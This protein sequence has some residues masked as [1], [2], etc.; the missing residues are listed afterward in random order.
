MKKLI[1]LFLLIACCIQANAQRNCTNPHRIFQVPKGKVPVVVKELG[2]APQF[3]I[4]CK[5][6][7]ADIFYKNLKTLGEIK[8]YK[9]EINSLFRSIGYSGVG[10][11]R[12][13]RDKVT[14]TTV[15]FGAVG[16]LGD[17]K[18]NYVYSILVLPEQNIKAWRITALSGCDLYFMN[19]CGNGF[20]YANPPV[21][22]ETVKYVERCTGN[23]KLKVRVVARYEKEECYVC[24]DGSAYEK[25][26]EKNME[27]AEEKIDNIPIGN[28]NSSYPVK[29]IYIDLDKQTFKKLEKMAKKEAQC[30]DDD[31]CCAD[32][33]DESCGDDCE[34]DSGCHHGSNKCCEGGKKHCD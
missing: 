2:S 10:D 18:H 23:A 17:S 16:M 26:I 5:L 21:E 4:M 34:K 32:D 33:C 14:K 8:E 12:F 3:P 31:S 27:V 20:Y 9:E 28:A 1:V 30:C 24:T 19:R 11:P 15:P 6:D 29:T 13:T 22:Y 25:E 7:D